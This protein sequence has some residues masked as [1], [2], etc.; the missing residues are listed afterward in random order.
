MQQERYSKVIQQKLQVYAVSQLLVVG[1]NTRLAL[2]IRI[3]GFLLLSKFLCRLDEQEMIKIM[4]GILSAMVKLLS[5]VHLSMKKMATLVIATVISR[6]GRYISKD[7]TSIDQKLCHV[8]DRVDQA[9]LQESS[10]IAQSIIEQ[11]LPCYA[12]LVNCEQSRVRVTSLIV[13]AYTHLMS[14][15]SFK[16]LNTSPQ[17][18]NDFK[19]QI[20]DRLSLKPLNRLLANMLLE[21]NGVC[22]SVDDEKRVMYINKTNGL[23]NLTETNTVP[24]D[25]VLDGIMFLYT[26]SRQ[27]KVQSE[28]NTLLRG[29]SCIQFQNFNSA[30]LELALDQFIQYVDWYSLVMPLLDRL[31]AIYCQ[32][33]SAVIITL[34]AVVPRLPLHLKL[35]LLEDLSSLL[36]SSTAAENVVDDQLYCAQLICRIYDNLERGD[37]KQKQVTARVL[38][39]S[40]QNHFTDCV[41][42]I[43][44]C[45]QSVGNLEDSDQSIAQLLQEFRN[46]IMNVLVVD[47]R[48][49][50]SI[51]KSLSIM[52]GWI[53]LVGSQFLQYSSIL[54]S[55]VL[56]RLRKSV[57][58]VEEILVSLSFFQ[59]CIVLVVNNQCKSTHSGRSQYDR[60]V[61][62]QVSQLIIKYPCASASVLRWVAEQKV[63]SDSQY[64]ID[65]DDKDEY[66]ITQDNEKLFTADEAAARQIID[67]LVD[68]LCH[69]QFAVRLAALKICFVG[70]DILN[71]PEN[72][73]M[74]ELW[75]PYLLEMLDDQ[76]SNSIQIVCQYLQRFLQNTRNLQ[77]KRVKDD[78]IPK[79]VN[80]IWCLQGKVDVHSQQFVAGLACI[81]FMQYLIKINA[82]SKSQQ[83]QL[84]VFCTT[85]SG[86]K[87]NL[88]ELVSDLQ[89]ELNQDILEY[90]ISINAKRTAINGNITHQNRNRSSIRL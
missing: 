76:Q 89:R 27:Q 83:V 67:S 26:P 22:Y 19:Q 78:V 44:S 86:Q 74:L 8:L 84:A 47:L 81:K 73:A 37:I 71:D 52:T 54:I 16:N 30:D 62:D 25:M 17:Y 23:C 88:K 50:Q 77:L 43:S 2:Q 33:R 5:Q 64:A 72:V 69:D 55:S 15:S 49:S 56:S 32:N 57:T 66:E 28:D 61:E 45:Y 65:P 12:A 34:C 68:F 75:W 70:I 53:Q 3:D 4:P 38:L 48:H 7:D 39:Y 29:A 6:G 51:V 31:N 36:V 40:L 18:N 14:S 87:A 60:S 63:H 82:V 79:I 10:T 11:F 90:T 13:H 80:M 35:R 9:V 59:E 42:S 20:I 46:E 85:F 41:K 58:D 21:F 24:A 1:V